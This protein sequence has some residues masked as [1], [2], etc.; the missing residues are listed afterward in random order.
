MEDFIAE[1]TA[2][3]GSLEE[4]AS[5]QEILI[6]QV[7]GYLSRMRAAVCADVERLRSEIL[8][9]TFLGLTDTPSSYS[10]DSA[11]VPAVNAGETALEFIVPT[12]G[13]PDLELDIEVSSNRQ[14][15]PF[16][17]LEDS[18]LKMVFTPL[19]NASVA[20]FSHGIAR[21]FTIVSMYGTGN[22]PASLIQITLP[23]V[24]TAFLAAGVSIHIE[25]PD[26][27]INTGVVNLSGFTDSYII[28]EYVKS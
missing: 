14:V 19:P 3:G 11:K 17:A 27:V 8:A 25:G 22:N 6:Q 26:I 24:N 23:S 15:A 18:F 28:L 12:L 4:A 21:P 13:P 9:G 5:T 1:A 20:F 16:G 7:E 2:Q 10:G